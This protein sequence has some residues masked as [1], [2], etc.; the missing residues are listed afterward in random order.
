MFTPTRT[1]AS[2]QSI[3]MLGRAPNQAKVVQETDLEPFQV[4]ELV[5][6][7][8]NAPMVEPGRIVTS[9]DKVPQVVEGAEIVTGKRNK[10]RERQELAEEGSFR[11]QTSLADFQQFVEIDQNDREEPPK[12]DPFQESSAGPP[13]MP[14]SARRLLPPS[15]GDSN[16]PPVRGSSAG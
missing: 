14:P 9:P 16:P 15:D 7:T 5:N 4:R 1:H 13:K 8:N 12:F 10:K 2:P 11:H 6:I 3:S